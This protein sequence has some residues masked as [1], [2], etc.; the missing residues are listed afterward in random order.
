MRRLNQL[1]NRFGS[2]KISRRQFMEGAIAL[3]LTVAM[4]DGL[5]TAALAA[6]PK[7]G[8]TFRLGL[9]GASTTD[10]LDPATYISTF[11]QIGFSFGVHNQLVE[12]AEDGSLRPELAESFE[13]SKDAK[14]WNFKLRKGVEFHNGKTLSTDDVIASIMHHRGADSKSALKSL[15]EP[16]EEIKADGDSVVIRLKDGNADFPFLMNDYHL[17]IVP[18]KDGKI[19]WQSGF[20]AGGYKLVKNNP[21]VTVELDRNPNYWKS[22]RAHFDKCILIGIPDAAARQNALVSGDVD[23]I[24]HV[25]L[26]TASLLGQNPGIVLEEVTGTQHY[27]IPMNVG[28]APF[29]NVD[30][31]LALKYAIDREAMVKAILFG[32]GRVGND[33]P[34]APANRYF[35]ADLEQRTYD[36]EKARFHLKKAG[37]DSLKVDLSAANTAFAGAVDVATLYAANAAKAGIEIN[38]I[39][40][41][42]DG[43]WSNVWM[44][45]PWT[46]SYWGGRPTE[47]WMF[48]IGYAAKGSWNETF[49]SN[50]RFMKLLVEARAELDEPKRRAMYHEMQAIVS[51]DGGAVVPMYAN[52]VDAR[53]DKVAHGD[54]VAT[55]W[56]LDGWKVL[57]RWWFA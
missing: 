21:G 47:D 43:Y 7:K 2:G 8:G 42:D 50:D 48:T 33:H 1:Q 19:D 30:V 9:G 40:E 14:T 12:V 10:E 52:Y 18:S 45:K 51:D 4:A 56:E 44:K 23:A 6:T 53:S 55:N 24:N 38:V 54:K 34:I 15:F 27:T 46:M 37:L 22:D 41:P 29:D 16:I 35:A 36:P 11:T 25:D 31:R 32:H 3:G 39:R 17:P 5:V 13:A 49:W 57:E 20:G 26:K 28:V